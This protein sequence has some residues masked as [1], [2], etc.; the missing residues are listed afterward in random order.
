VSERIKQFSAEKRRE[1]CTYDSS[2]G[3]KLVYS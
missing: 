3:C 2:C 1:V